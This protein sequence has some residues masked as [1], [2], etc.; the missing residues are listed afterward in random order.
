MSKQKEVGN[1][2]ENVQFKHVSYSDHTELVVYLGDGKNICTVGSN[3]ERHGI[4]YDVYDYKNELIDVF[5]NALQAVRD[6][7]F[8][9]VKDVAIAQKMISEYVATQSYSIDRKALNKKLQA[10]TENRNEAED[11][12]RASDLW[13]SYFQQISVLYGKP[14]AYDAKTINLYEGYLNDLLE[15][16][17]KG[18]NLDSVK[19]LTERASL[20]NK[21][22]GNVHNFGEEVLQHLI[23]KL[24]DEQVKFVKGALEC[25][26]P[27]DSTCKAYADKYRKE[28]ALIRSKYSAKQSDK[29]RSEI[30]NAQSMYQVE[31]A[32]CAK[33]YEQTG[34][35]SIFMKKEEKEAFD[36]MSFGEMVD[37]YDLNLFKTHKGAIMI[38][39]KLAEAKEK[40]EEELG[41]ALDKLNGLFDKKKESFFSLAASD[42]VKY[43][44]F[45]EVRKSYQKF[46][47]HDEK[48]R[49]IFKRMIPAPVKQND[50]KEQ[51]E[52]GKDKRLSSRLILRKKFA[53]EVTELATGKIDV[54]KAMKKVKKR[55]AE[56]RKQVLE[57]TGFEANAALAAASEKGYIRTK[58][59]VEAENKAVAKKRK[60]TLDNMMNKKK[61]KNK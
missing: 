24:T 3:K 10:F 39:L 40:G 14:G 37:A 7:S 45:K 56:L 17:E 31:D 19:S 16:R 12:Y 48:F 47:M 61:E 43:R 29:L 5:D 22:S 54:E 13:R 6:V 27:G 2:L 38:G 25:G 53:V 58:Q 49:G 11:A 34:D 1:F 41:N 30:L 32:L 36:K 28:A 44:L 33:Y 21:I 9:D 18:E 8:A 15:A 46:G 57:N 4:P 42:E 23:G 55:E 59:A 60:A 51:D 35:L 26:F 20:W 52:S 50:M